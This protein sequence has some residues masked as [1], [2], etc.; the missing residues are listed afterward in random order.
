LRENH[1]G[2]ETQWNTLTSADVIVLRENH[3]GMETLKRSV[4]TF[5]FI[6]QLRENHSGMETIVQS[7]GY[8]AQGRVA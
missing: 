4:P 2:M 8:C 3:S 7:P 6:S 1:S 5:T